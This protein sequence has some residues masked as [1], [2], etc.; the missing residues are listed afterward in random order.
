MVMEGLEQQARAGQKGL[1]ADPQPVPP[2]EWQK[3]GREHEHPAKDSL[4]EHF[5]SLR[6]SLSVVNLKQAISR[7]N[8]YVFPA[9]SFYGKITKNDL[10]P[11]E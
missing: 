8:P 2:W 4:S 11:P 7:Y 9:C 5:G 6:K 1:W 3:L 10:T